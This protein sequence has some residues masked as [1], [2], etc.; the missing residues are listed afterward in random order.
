MEVTSNYSGGEIE[1]R[2]CDFFDDDDEG[3][4]CDIWGSDEESY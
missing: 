3:S 1:S 4:G 2:S